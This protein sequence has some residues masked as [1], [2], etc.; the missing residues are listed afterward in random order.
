M[1][2]TVLKFE[3]QGT[4]ILSVRNNEIKAI[5]PIDRKNRNYI[6]YLEWIAKGNV[7]SVEAPYLADESDELKALR[8]KELNIKAVRK[9][10]SEIDRTD[11][12]TVVKL[13]RVVMH[14]MDI[15]EL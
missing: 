7:A 11:L 2:Y 12:N 1:K 3:F 15:L 9:T 5:I 13:R 10:L 8:A 14:L 4:E 6:E